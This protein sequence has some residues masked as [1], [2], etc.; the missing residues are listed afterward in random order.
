MSFSFLSRL[1]F[2]IRTFPVRRHDFGALQAKLFPVYFEY[3]VLM[4]SITCG[5]TYS[6]RKKI[7]DKE[8]APLAASLALNLINLFY[9]EPKTTKIMFKRHALERELGAGH[10]IGSLKPESAKARADPRLKEISKQ[11][12]KLHGL[13]TTV[14]LIALCCGTYHVYTQIE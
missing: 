7:F 11:F 2:L 1:A 3:S 14:N 10:E 4:L 9:L 8:I 5:A 6:L 13:S 12:G